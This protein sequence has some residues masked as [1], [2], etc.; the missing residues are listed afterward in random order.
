MNS[1]TKLAGLTVAQFWADFNW[2]GRPNES[3]LYEESPDT[4]NWLQLDIKTFFGRANWDGRS[5]SQT[6][7]KQPQKTLSLTLSVEEY[8]EFNPWRSPA[9]IAVTPTKPDL[10]PHPAR[11]LNVTDL[12]NLF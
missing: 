11:D 12:A 6:T 9:N 5:F 2:W 8:F 10:S 3:N 7:V 1:Q 4:S